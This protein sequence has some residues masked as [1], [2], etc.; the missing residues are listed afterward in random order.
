MMHNS[1]MLILK[2]ISVS[3]RNELNFTASSAV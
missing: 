3:F 2:A 1:L